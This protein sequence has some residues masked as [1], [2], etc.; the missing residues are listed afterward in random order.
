[1]N[2]IYDEKPSEFTCQDHDANSARLA[3]A[4]VPQ[5]VRMPIEQRIPIIAEMEPH[6]RG[7]VR[8]ACIVIDGAERVWCDTSEIFSAEPNRLGC[9]CEIKRTEYG[10]TLRV[11]NKYHFTRS[12]GATGATLLPVL[13]LEFFEEPD[14]E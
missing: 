9:D 2:Q 4:T 1:M 3:T 8:T 14:E 10:V 5:P 6:E 11:P 13:E 7:F 12:R